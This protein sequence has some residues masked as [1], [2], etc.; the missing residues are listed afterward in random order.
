MH[1]LR[2]NYKAISLL[3]P[4]SIATTTTGTGVDIEQYEDD[5]LFIL[6]LG[7]QGGTTETLDVT[8]QTSVIGDF[9]DAV[10]AVTFGQVTGTNGDNL[11][12]AGFASL[13]GIK[14]V[15]AV[16]TKSSTGADLISVVMLARVRVGGS[17]TNSVTPA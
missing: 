3:K 16:A 13:A 4:Q 17:T 11:I 8:I 12:A 10:T 14:K 6:D 1:T 7:A 5:A 2:D 9:T 15:R